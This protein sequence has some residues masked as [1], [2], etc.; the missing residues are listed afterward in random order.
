VIVLAQKEKVDLSEDDLNYWLK[1]VGSLNPLGK[2]SMRQDIEAK[3][4][5]ELELFAGTIVRLGKKHAIPTPVN[6][7][8]YDGIRDL[9]SRY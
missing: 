2:P 9:E 6:R 1:V 4:P 8:L 3:R 5:S 7:M